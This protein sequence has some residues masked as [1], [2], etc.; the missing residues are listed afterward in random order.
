M[1]ALDESMETLFDWLASRGLVTLGGSMDVSGIDLNKP[2]LIDGSQ[3]AIAQP[4]ARH[5]VTRKSQAELKAVKQR[6]SAQTPQGITNIAVWGAVKDP[7]RAVRRLNWERLPADAMA[8]YR[9]FHFPPFDQW[10]I[11]LLVGPLL[12]YHSRLQALSA[13]L[14]LYSREV[15]MH[16]VVFEIF[17]HEFFHHLAES[18]ATSLEIL[19]AARG[20]VEA[21]YLSYRADARENSYAD[22]HA[23]LEEALANAYAY[24]ALSFVSRIKAGYKTAVVKSYQEAIKRH[25]HLEPPGYQYAGYYIDGAYV[26]GGAHLLAQMI[27]DLEAV[28]ETP[29]CCL[30]KHLMPSGFTALMQKPDIPTYLVGNAHDLNTFNALVPAPNEAY[31]QLFWPYDTTAIDRYVEQKRAEERAKAKQRARKVASPPAQLSLFAD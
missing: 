17:N 24:N 14:Q 9:P 31:T 30:A 6:Y 12:E 22:P 29:L 15:L 5:P 20:E 13:P 2:E 19:A 3:V 25:W 4:T 11:Y 18:T 1:P 16:L 27:G 7:T 10:G 26:A 23:P 28:D 8:F 21:V